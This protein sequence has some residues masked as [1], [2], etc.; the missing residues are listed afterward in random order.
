[1]VGH[2][3]MGLVA[4]LEAFGA[5]VETESGESVDLFEEAGGVEHDAVADD[6]HLA[7]MKDTGRHH[8]QDVF[9]AVYDDGMAR[10][11]AAL[12]TDHH[13]HFGSEQ[14][15]DLAFAFVAPLRTNDSHVRHKCLL[16]GSSGDGWKLALHRTHQAPFIKPF[17]IS[18]NMQGASLKI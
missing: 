4:D 12:E 2:D 17:H 3:E 8:M 9:L 5:H 16:E 11:V 10:V 7:G 13:I 15:D 6:A 18:V 14:I 1:M